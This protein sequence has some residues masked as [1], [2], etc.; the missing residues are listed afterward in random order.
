LRFLLLQESSCD[1]EAIFGPTMREMLAVCHLPLTVDGFISQPRKE[2]T[3][4]R[5]QTRDNRMFRARSLQTIKNRIVAETAFPR[6]SYVARH[7]QGHFG[8][9][10]RRESCHRPSCIFISRSEA[11]VRIERNYAVWLSPTSIQTRPPGWTQ[12]EEKLVAGG[13]MREA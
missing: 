10:A 2:G 4:T 13:M 8:L 12:D 5:S 11:D 7:A 3:E 1:D 6:T 9:L